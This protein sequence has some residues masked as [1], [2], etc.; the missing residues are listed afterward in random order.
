[1]IC[2]SKGGSMKYENPVME[3]TLL[4]VDMIFT[5]LNDSGDHTEDGGGGGIVLPNPNAANLNV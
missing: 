3:V 5:S 2:A 4:E 1:M